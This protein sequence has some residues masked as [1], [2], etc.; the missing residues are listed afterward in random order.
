MNKFMLWAVFGVA[1]VSVIYLGSNFFVQVSREEAKTSVPEIIQGLYPGA[2]ILSEPRFEENCTT[3]PEGGCQE[4]GI[5]CWKVIVDP[6][7]SAENLEIVLAAGGSGSPNGGFITVYPVAS[8]ECTYF[9]SAKTGGTTI[10]TYNT[11]CNNPLPAC[12]QAAFLCRACSTASDCLR[13]TV[14]KYDTGPSDYYFYQIIGSLFHG[15][16]KTSDNS[17][18]LYI[19]TVNIYSNNVSAESDCKSIALSRALCR[20]D[21]IC[22]F[23]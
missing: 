2:S 15:T 21:G 14:H 4:I 13:L 7:E 8:G 3:C 19:N 20:E 23:I 16:F 1:L 12:D 18:K 6:V 17:C 9:S 11:G 22:E 10:D 5:P